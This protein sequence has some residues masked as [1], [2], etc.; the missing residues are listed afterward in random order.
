MDK[1]KIAQEVTLNCIKRGYIKP[2]S[3]TTTLACMLFAVHIIK[4]F[5]SVYYDLGLKGYDL[6]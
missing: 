4:I 5:H 6:K 3:R 2:M 1:Y